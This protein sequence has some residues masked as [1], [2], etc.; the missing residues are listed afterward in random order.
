MSIQQKPLMP[1]V[2]VNGHIIA[3][4]DIAAEAQNHTAPTGKPGVAWRAAARALVV[5]RLLLDEAKRLGL[6]AEP[7]EIGRG[8]W[9]TE[10]EALI[11][12]LVEQQIEPRPVSESDC[13]AFFDDPEN[14]FNGPDLYEPQHILV[15]ADPKDVPARDRARLK[16]ETLFKTLIHQPDKIATLASSES[17][18][19]SKSNGGMLG[20][21]GPGDTVAEFENALKPLA[22][23]RFHDG[24]LETRYGFHIIFMRNRAEGRALPYPAVRAHIREQLE[25][26][27]WVNASKSYISGLMNAAQVIGLIAGIRGSMAAGPNVRGQ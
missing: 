23:G 4:A 18:C 10:E 11:R 3:S 17:D 21:I 7:Q 15:A 6:R 8:K 13:R 24:V 1:E 14:C 2:S 9:E 25:K 26:L 12:A 19:P 20:Q 5:R 16:A 22:M 27:A